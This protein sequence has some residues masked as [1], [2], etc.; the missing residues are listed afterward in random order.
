MGRMGKFNT[1]TNRFESTFLS[2]NKDT[3][4]IIKR[5]FVDNPYKEDLLRLLVVNTPDCLTD[6]T[7]SAYK[8][9]IRTMTPAKLRQDGYLKLSPKI[10]LKENEEAKS[11]I[12]ISFTSF[13]PTDN[14]YYRDCVM[15]I[16]I[17]CPIDEF[18]MDNYGIRPLMIAGYIDAI[19]NESKLSGIGTLQFVGMSEI[20]LEENLGGYCLMYQSTHG[21]DDVTPVEDGEED[22]DELPSI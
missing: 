15:T 12:I 10:G 13:V 5:L 7:N 20:T 2:A 1:Y 11:Y 16:D 21:A 19:L 8:A 6:R 14:H 3:E 22:E 17:Q 9:K 18:E 4:E